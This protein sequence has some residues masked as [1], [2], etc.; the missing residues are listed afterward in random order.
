MNLICFDVMKK[1]EKVSEICNIFSEFSKQK[2]D[3][4]SLLVL[5]FAKYLCVF[6]SVPEKVIS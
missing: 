3:C 5:K 4:F 6:E 1:C 2:K